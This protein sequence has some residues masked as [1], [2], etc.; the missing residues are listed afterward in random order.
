MASSRNLALAV[1]V[2]AIALGVFYMIDPTLAGLLGRKAEG[3]ESGEVK[4]W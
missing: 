3:F 4:Y 1:L 2:V